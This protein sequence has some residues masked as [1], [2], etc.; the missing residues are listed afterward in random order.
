MTSKKNEFDFIKEQLNPLTYGKKEARNLVDD[1]A[2]FKNVEGLTISVDTSIEGIHVPTGTSVEIQSERSVL[3]ALSDLAAFGAK[4][5]CIFA[6]ISLPKTFKY[7]LLKEISLGLKRVLDDYKIFIA[8]GDISSYEGPLNF[9]ITVL[10][11]KTTN[12]AGRSGAKP[13]DLVVMSGNLGDSYIGRMLIKKNYYDLKK[14][15][16][17]KLIKKFYK[18]SPRISLGMII[19]KFSTSAI[20]ISDGLLSELN[21]I[22]VNSNVGAFINVEK[23]PLSKVLKSVIENKKIRYL[24]ILTGGDDYELLYTVNPSNI[25]RLDSESSVIGEIVKKSGIKVIGQN[26]LALKFKKDELGYKHF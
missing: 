21:H 15:E 16:T 18:P 14:E 20:D 3:R 13:G 25:G 10:G 7:R 4:P 8:G 9:S 1:C 12:I 26:S 6:A 17:K 11:E 22:C 24:D 2:F 5:L 19:N 23:L